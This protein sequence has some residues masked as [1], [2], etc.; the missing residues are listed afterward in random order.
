[1]RVRM[2]TLACGPSGTFPP[3][4]EREVSDAEGAALVAARAAVALDAPKA[5]APEAPARE[6]EAPA[7]KGRK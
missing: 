2:T 5:P 6:P 7:K 4:A 3:G 1:M